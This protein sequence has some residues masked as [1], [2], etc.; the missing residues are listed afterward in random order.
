MRGNETSKGEVHVIIDD[1]DFLRRD[2]IELSDRPNGDTT[3]IHVSGRLEQVG[4]LGFEQIAVEPSEILELRRADGR[5]VSRREAICELIYDEETG[6]VPC[7]LIFSTGIAETKDGSDVGHSAFFR[8]QPIPLARLLPERL[9]L[10]LPLRPQPVPR[11]FQRRQ[12]PR[13]CQ[14][15]R[16]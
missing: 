15:T 3:V 6:I 8:K 2:A 14:P 11:E 9:L 1:E 13:R 10:L 5:T 7:V 4:P 16:D 12:Q